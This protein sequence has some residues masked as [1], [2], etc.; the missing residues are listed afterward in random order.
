M[1]PGSTQDSGGRISKP[2]SDQKTVNPMQMFTPT[3]R[4][5]P[6]IPPAAD[7][8]NGTSYVP[9]APAAARA[10]GGA[11]LSAGVSINGSLTFGQ[12][13]HV[14]CELE[15]TIDSEGKLIVG[16]NAQ[17]SGEIRVGSVTVLGTVEGNVIATERCEL[18]AGC[19]LRGDI[20]AP[21][22][23]VDDDATFV[24]SA[25]ITKRA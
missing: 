1:L 22:L 20:E 25:K 3:R 14:D 15:G 7:P 19:T 17:I 23:V 21:R 2:V 11:I 6:P 10:P 24:G 8:T 16:K 18:R 12:E 13:L 9:P 5:E 4:P